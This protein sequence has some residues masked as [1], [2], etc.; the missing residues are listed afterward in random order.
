MGES[1]RLVAE[2]DF[3]ELK[4]RLKLIFDADPEQ[5]QNDY[6]LRRSVSFVISV[7]IYIRNL[8]HG[9]FVFYRYLRAFKT[10]DLAFQVSYSQRF[11]PTR[12]TEN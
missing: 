6:A 4:N 5:Y 12:K 7:L 10:V 9:I 3:E 11:S 8:V 2:G 1:S